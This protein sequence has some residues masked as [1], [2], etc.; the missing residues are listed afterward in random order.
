[1]ERG[2]K[3]TVNFSYREWTACGS[4]LSYIGAQHEKLKR[5]ILCWTNLQNPNSYI[6]TNLNALTFKDTEALE[7]APKRMK[8]KKVQGVDNIDL[9]SLTITGPFFEVALLQ[10][11]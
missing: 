5:Q 4:G 6:V 1:M 2:K 11:V 8:D 9:Y 3:T 7:R 10:L